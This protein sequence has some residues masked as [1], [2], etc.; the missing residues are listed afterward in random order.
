MTTKQI[1]QIKL[2]VPKVAEIKYIGSEP[3]WETVTPENRKVRIIA[4]LNWYNYSF[5]VKESKS[6]MAE[7]LQ[8]N[9]KLSQAKIVATAPDAQ[10]RVA[11]GWLCRMSMVGLEL[12]KQELDLI[13]ADADRVCQHKEAIKE[14]AAANSTVSNKPTIQ[15]RLQEKMRECAAELDGIFDDILTG[16]T[17]IADA[18]PPINCIR[19][20]NVVAQQIAELRSQW[21]KRTAEL[22][23]VQTGKDD[24]LVEAY[25]NLG[26]M[27]I[28]N[29]IKY[30]DQVI[31]DCD[32]YLQIKKVERKPRKKKAVSPEKIV[33]NIKYQLQEPSLKLKSESPVK[34][35]GSTEVWLFDTKK[36]KLQHYVCDSHIG[37]M[38][39]K[40]NSLIGFDAA[41]STQ[42]TIRKPE[43][44]VTAIHASVPAARKY[45]T[46]IKAV[47]TKLTGRFN[48]NLIILRVK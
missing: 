4:A 28:R 39:V 18:V 11:I 32:S 42:K 19:T 29:L 1:K 26:K 9:S 31:S 27:Q 36:R 30:C 46:A 10:I 38:T 43:E 2:L 34:L 35:H 23:L 47:E 25:S 6:Y 3:T 7:W 37:S 13:Y 22:K 15:D 12:N 40:G 44:M 20:H 14:A 45:F 17:K 8:S 33:A 21:E 5:G 41:K 16:T 48:E 24:Y